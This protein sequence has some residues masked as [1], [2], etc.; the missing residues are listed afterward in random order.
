MEEASSPDRTLH[1]KVCLFS[2]LRDLT[3]SSHH[4]LALTSPACGR[5]VLDA[6]EEAFP[7]FRPYRDVIRLAVNLEYAS[8]GIP[9]ND[10]D[11]VAIITPVS[12]G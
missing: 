7:A 8:D 4:H 6:M 9:L 10:G 2:S 5:D 12:G 3:G 1:V 11:E